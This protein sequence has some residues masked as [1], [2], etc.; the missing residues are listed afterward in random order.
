MTG[1]EDRYCPNLNLDSIGPGSYKGFNLE[2]LLQ[3]FEEDFHMPTMFVN[4]SDR[5]RSELRLIR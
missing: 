2:V 1:D 3:G 4:D 5:G